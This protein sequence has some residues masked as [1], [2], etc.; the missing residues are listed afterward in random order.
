L[1]LDLVG[2]SI[3]RYGTL[4]SSVWVVIIISWSVRQRQIFRVV[5][6]IDCVVLNFE[7]RTFYFMART[8][9]TDAMLC[10]II[11][12]SRDRD[13]LLNSKISHK[14]Y[15]ILYTV[16]SWACMLGGGEN[17]NELQDFDLNTG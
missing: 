14:K 12:Y 7:I 1:D 16:A 11:L 15:V 17:I 10:C 9:C 8:Y 2:L 13:S 3:S 4:A 6:H 5:L